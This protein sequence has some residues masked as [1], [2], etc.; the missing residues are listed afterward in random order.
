MGMASH[1]VYRQSMLIPRADGAFDAEVELEC[2][3]ML[4]LVVPGE[5]TVVLE[6][7]ERRV[8]GK[9]ACPADHPVGR[10]LAR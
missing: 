8:A 7:G 3:C 9:Y 1:S 6:S 2:G 5:R 10:R 4:T